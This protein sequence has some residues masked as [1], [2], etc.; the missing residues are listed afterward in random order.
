M[1]RRH[2]NAILKTVLKSA[3]ILTLTGAAV[4]GSQSNGI[5][6]NA[7]SDTSIS[8]ELNPAP[9]SYGYFVDSSIKQKH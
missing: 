6:A 9:A 1:G 4:L 5:K 7:K 3:F 8:S 2:S